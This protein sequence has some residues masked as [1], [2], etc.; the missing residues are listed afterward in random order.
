MFG[1]FM[2]AVSDVDM[3][4]WTV[5]VAA[6]E[7][8]EGPASAAADHEGAPAKRA[9]KLPGWA[10]AWLGC[11]ES[12][13][14]A[15]SSSG[16]TAPARPEI[17]S[18]APLTEEQEAEVASE[19]AEIRGWLAAVLPAHVD[20]FS[21]RVLGGNWTRRFRHNS[22]D[23]LQ[24]YCRSDMAQL[25][26]YQFD[27]QQTSRF[28]RTQFGRQDAY[29]LALSWCQRMSFYFQIWQECDFAAM[30]FT[31]AEAD[32][33]NFD[34][35]ELVEAMLAHGQDS[36]MWLRGAEIRGMVPGAWQGH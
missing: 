2:F 36:P 27:L 22:W 15:A 5:F 12:T 1:F 7:W 3:I 10:S 18:D 16:D 6:M 35:L 14:G 26:A 9:K 31:G 13:G 11:S 34:D 33:N 20:H 19:L 29:L 24:G 21:I 28:G 30:D 17:I 8:I 32:N 4:P 25:F 23:A